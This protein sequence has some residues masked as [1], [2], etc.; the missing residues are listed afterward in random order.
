VQEIALAA[1]LILRGFS[2]RAAQPRTAAGPARAGSPE[3][4]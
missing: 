3:A 1:W 4:A 2:P